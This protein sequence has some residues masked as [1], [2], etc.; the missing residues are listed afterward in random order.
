[1]E[2]IVDILGWFGTCLLVLGYIMISAKKVHGQSISYQLFNLIGSIFFG[3]SSYYYGALPSVGISIMW[4]GICA[5][6]RL[7]ISQSTKQHFSV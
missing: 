2:S 1:M 5:V 7:Q 6:R 4:I 3:V